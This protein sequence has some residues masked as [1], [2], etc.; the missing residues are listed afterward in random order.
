MRKNFNL[1]TLMPRDEAITRLINLLEDESLIVNKTN[2]R[3]W[4]QHTP[5][6]IVNFDSRLYSKKN[7][8]GINPFIFITSIDINFESNMSDKTFITVTIDRTRMLFILAIVLIIVTALAI[9]APVIVSATVA[10]SLV[11]V[12][13]I[14][15]YLSYSLA[16]KEI[17]CEIS[18]KNTH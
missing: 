4:S 7:W 13:F 9:Q 11:G 5:L 15:F 10:A 12:F 2:N 16:R 1:E 18:D 14:L 6:P 8:V 3:I 17:E